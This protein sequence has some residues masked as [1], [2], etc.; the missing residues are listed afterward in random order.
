M[1]CLTLRALHFDTRFPFS[2]Y[3]NLYR[4]L[5][6]LGYHLHVFSQKHDLPGRIIWHLA[7]N[8]TEIAHDILR[9]SNEPNEARKTWILE[10]E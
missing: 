8:V 1:L 9:N 3:A 7:C 10:K 6:G 4:F 2:V 5:N